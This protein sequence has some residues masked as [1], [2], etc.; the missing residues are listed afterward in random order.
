LDDRPA[1]RQADVA[2]HAQGD[3]DHG[4]DAGREAHRLGARLARLPEQ[5][6]AVA[7]I[8]GAMAAFY[9]YP[10]DD[11]GIVILTNL[12]GA[13]PEQFIEQVAQLYGSDPP[14]L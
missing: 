12:A 1:R 7:G 5:H 3:V 14:P 4:Q 2:R 11:V 10:E 6:P 13:Q 9:I 8:G